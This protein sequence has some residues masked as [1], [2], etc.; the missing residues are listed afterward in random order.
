MPL[1]GRGEGLLIAECDSIRTVEYI[2]R[3]K[4]EHKE[5]GLCGAHAVALFTYLLPTRVT[6]QWSFVPT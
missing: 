6:D 2:E 5:T 4:T 3:H 1:V